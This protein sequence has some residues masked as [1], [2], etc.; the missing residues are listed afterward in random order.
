[1]FFSSLG[2]GSAICTV[3][4][5][6]NKEIER[7]GMQAAIGMGVF[8]GIEG[9]LLL[10]SLALRP[11]FTARQMKNGKKSKFFFARFIL[12]FSPL[13]SGPSRLRVLN[14]LADL[15]LIPSNAFAV[16]RKAN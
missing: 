14:L 3:A 9:I 4:G 7:W 2:Y 12:C 15:N 10:F 13:F 6:K 8:I 16:F 11:Q 5:W 1:M